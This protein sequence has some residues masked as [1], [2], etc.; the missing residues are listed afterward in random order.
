ML[1]QANTDG[2]QIMVQLGGPSVGACNPTDVGL[3]W[4]EGSST[5]V[6]A[7]SRYKW[8]KPKL[9]VIW[10]S[11]W[12]IPY[13][14]S[15][16][17]TDVRY[18]HSCLF[19]LLEYDLYYALYGFY[20]WTWFLIASPGIRCGKLYALR[21]H[22]HPTFGLFFRIRCGW[23]RRGTRSVGL[24]ICYYLYLG[25]VWY[26]TRDVY[27]CFVVLYSLCHFLFVVSVWDTGLYDNLNLM[28]LVNL[29]YF[30]V[31]VVFIFIVIAL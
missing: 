21:I 26:L 27:I 28:W 30:F 16:E 12:K 6:I 24:G 14:I 25:Y 10:T 7:T 13:R 11:S 3:K 31:C 2:C 19:M 29:F 4:S 8:V 1:S 18:M 5:S 17:L 22:S 9:I 23:Y 15:L 20:F